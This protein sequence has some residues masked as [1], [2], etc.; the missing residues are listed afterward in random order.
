MRL[1]IRNCPNQKRLAV[2]VFIFSLLILINLILFSSPLFG[3]SFYA[4]ANSTP[5]TTVSSFSGTLGENNWY[6]STVYVTLGVSDLESGPKSTTYWLDT[7]PP[8]TNTY[9]S[10]DNAILN[11][12]FENGD[13]FAGTI[14][15]WEKEGYG[16][17]FQSIVFYKFDWRSAAIWANGDSGV[18]AWHNRSNAVSTVSGE[19]Y[20]F[21]VWLKTLDISGLGAWF[22]VW[23]KGSEPALDQLVISSSVVNGMNDWTLLSES[24]VMPAG[25]SS[26]Y[27]KLKMKDE[28]LIGAAY[29]DGASLYTGSSAITEFTAVE[30]GN[31]T[32]HFYSTDNQGNT[33]PEQQVSL[34][35]DTVAPQDW[36]NFSYVQGGCSHCYF[37]YLDVK[38]VTSGIDVSSAQYRFYSNHQ[39]W[40]WS[41]WF[42]VASV[43]V[44][45][46][47]APATDGETAF[48]KLATPEIDF[49]DNATVYR[50]QFAISDM[51]GNLSNSPIQTIEGPWIK[52]EMA[53]LYAGA[54]IDMIASAPTGKTNSNSI[55]YCGDG[56][57]NFTSSDSRVFTGYTHAKV[58]VTSLEDLLSYWTELVS[59]ASPLPENRLPTTSG[60]YKYEGNYTIDKNTLTSGFQSQ[61]LSTVIILQGNL[62]IK[63]SFSMNPVSSAV[64][65]VQGDVEVEGK[66]EDIFGVYLLVGKFY[67]NID[68][69][70][71]NQLRVRGAVTSLGG[72]AL[73]RDLGRTGKYDNGVDPA[74]KFTFPRHYFF[75]SKLAE[76]INI[77]ARRYQWGEIFP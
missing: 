46:T 43:T 19:N 69:K 34:K 18:S 57:T 51:A 44:V 42:S 60:L 30:N 68:N 21:S 5:P 52:V 1:Q 76:L 15:Y 12:S 49:G 33:E 73:G 27:V 53:E 66:V 20:S 65:L 22:E 38:D 50:V 4:L 48:V 74:E 24:F 67:S 9:T 37:A 39:A 26:V 47:G 29:W 14:N 25:F 40:G 64:F 17:L 3:P 71:E 8:I 56:I 10:T 72:F 36:Q 58:D 41:A 61:A 13:F 70:Y 2:R 75:D 32:L 31:H 54:G 63:A 11:P 6:V 7:N 45:S 28:G 23:A 16:L 62:R 55:V 35:I 59:T 77:K